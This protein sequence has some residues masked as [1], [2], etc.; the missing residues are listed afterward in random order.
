M[1]SQKLLEKI[2]RKLC[3]LFIIVHCKSYALVQSFN[4]ISAVGVKQRN[5][6]FKKRKCSPKA[7]N[8]M[9]HNISFYPQNIEKRQQSSSSATSESVRESWDL[10]R[11]G[12][13]LYILFSKRVHGKNGES[14]A[15][16]QKYI[17]SRHIR[18]GM[19]AFAFSATKL[20]C[21]N[22]CV[23]LRGKGNC[24]CIYIL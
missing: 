13:G 14:S 8:Q 16:I 2:S 9:Y 1:V 17:N 19:P 7:K 12:N 24:Y 5:S 20:A 15:Q 23:G 21:I 3:T 11:M 22:I 18:Q 6:H 4:R 10:H